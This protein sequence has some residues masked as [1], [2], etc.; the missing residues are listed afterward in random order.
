MQKALGCGQRCGRKTLLRSRRF[1][2][3][4]SLST[5]GEEKLNTNGRGQLMTTQ[6]AML[7]YFTSD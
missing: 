3:N 7:K 1:D 2:E 6:S 4:G 5:G